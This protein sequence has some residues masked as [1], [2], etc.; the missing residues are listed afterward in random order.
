MIIASMICAV[1]GAFIV[2]LLVPARWQAHTRVMLNLLKPDPVTG[3]MV[4]EQ[5][6][7]AYANTQVE[8]ITDYSVVGQ[9][10]DELG[11]LS[12]PKLI[13]SYNRR[14]KS[15]HRDFRRWLAQTVIDNT[16]AAI[17]QGS[18]ILEITYTATTP[19]NAKAVADAL[20]TAY[21][22]ASLEF[23]RDDAERSA[24]WFTAQAQKAK[25]E[26]DLAVS[27]RA[28][29]EK[30]NGIVM[31]DD[32]TDIESAHLQALAMQSGLAPP[33][34]A[35][36]PALA[37]Q[38]AI[39]LAQVKAQIETASE[40][41]GPNHPDL[42]A[43]RARRDALAQLV[44]NDQQAVHTATV[45]ANSA[46]TSAVDQLNHAVASQKERVI[47]KSD[48]IGRLTQLQAEVE[49][50]RDEFQTATTKAAQFRQEAAIADTGLVPL[51]A[52]VTPKAPVFPNK[53]LIIPGSAVLGLAAGVVFALLMELFNR[54]IRGVED[55]RWAVDA[56]LLAVISAPPSNFKAARMFEW[57]QL[58][59]LRLPWPFRRRTMAT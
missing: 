36:A 27:A 54:R 9:V 35:P 41:L 19:E 22:N 50:R 44:L 42:Q 8:L 47:A 52:A 6:T 28:E 11:W 56:P 25:T 32:K 58:L 1:I 18:N 51:G 49:L 5:S 55:L 40:T 3:L 53:V 14:S 24:E 57:P 29:F 48:Q 17:L 46:T 31:A 10:A 26:F 16:K 30:A 12:D 15:D 45:A 7:E 43:L 23:R 34:S 39:E 4:G 38:S 2:I 21:L 59:R 37:S 13:A 20:R 33:F